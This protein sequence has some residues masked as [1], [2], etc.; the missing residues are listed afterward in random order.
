[1]TASALA[2]CPPKAKI[3]HQRTTRRIGRN[4][5]DYAKV[6][7]RVL[8]QVRE[9]VIIHWLGDMFDPA[10]AGYWGTPD[11]D[12]AMD[13]AVEIINANAAKVDGIMKP[14][15]DA[16]VS[17]KAKAGSLTQANDQVNALFK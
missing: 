11:L 15:M 13:I 17:G 14:A 8:S 10:L 9:P 2:K 3:D 1:M 7:N 5:D 6:Y 4:A 12:K 16:V